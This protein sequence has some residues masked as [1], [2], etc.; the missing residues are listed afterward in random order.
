MKIAIVTTGGTIDKD[1]FDALSEYQV[2]ESPLTDL[3]E[4]YRVGFEFE[5]FALFRKDSLE[6]TDQ[7][8]TTIHDFV[9]GLPH[10][11]VLITH[12]SDTMVETAKAL[13]AL[14]NKT[15]VLTGAFK[16]ARFK[17]SDAVFNVGVAIGAIQSLLPGCYIAMNGLVFD[18]DNVVKNRDKMQFQSLSHSSSDSLSSSSSS[19]SSE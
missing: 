8:R 6:L 11:K 17:D 12:G 2:A 13:M 18:S 7:D 10:Q 4:H 15:I 19:S 5:M 3:L 1:Y 14:K 9:A 16:P